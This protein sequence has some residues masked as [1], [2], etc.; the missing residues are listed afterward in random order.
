MLGLLAGATVLGPIMALKGSELQ[1][2]LNI[3]SYSRFS[4]SFSEKWGLGFS[5]SYNASYIKE[6]FMT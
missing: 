6:Q 2:I 3:T 4:I 1:D 5:A